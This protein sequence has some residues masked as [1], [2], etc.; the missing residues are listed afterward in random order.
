MKIT[1]YFP[2]SE[3][4]SDFSISSPLNN[5]LFSSALSISKK[6]LSI[7]IF[8]VFPNLL[9]RVNNFTSEASSKIS[10]INSVLST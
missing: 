7:D 9:G 10:E 1:G 5:F 2:C 3:K 6:Y 4:Y 8:K